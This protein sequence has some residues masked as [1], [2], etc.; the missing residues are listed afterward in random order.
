M[1]DIKFIR[2]NKDIVSAGAKKKHIKFDADNLLAID[3]KRKELLSAVEDLRNKQN[4]AS[5]IISKAASGE[6]RASLIEEMKTLKLALQEK[7]SELAEVMKEWQKLMLVVPNVPDMSVPD[8]ESEEE[9]VEVKKW[10]NLPSFDFPV[11]DHIDLMIGN[12]MVDLER[13]TK[14]HGFRGYFLMNEGA[15]LSFAVWNYARQFFAGEGITEVIAPSIVR[16]EYFYGTGHLPN[17]AEDLFETQDGDYLSGTAEVPMMA[18]H[19][20]EILK[21]E[22]LPKRYLAFSPCF[23]REAGSH[24][25]DTKGLIRVHEFYKF[26]QLI[27]CEGRHEESE[28]LHEEI[29]LKSESFVESLGLPYRRLNVCSGDLSAS[30]V[31]QYEL[32]VWMP[33]QGKYR[34]IGSSSYYHDFQTRRFNIRYDDGGVKRYAHSL[35]N[36]AVATPRVLAAIIENNQREDGKIS[37]PM[38][39]RPFLGGAETIG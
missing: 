36:T 21:K 22:D 23:R 16:K 39:L 17:D 25:K 35:N 12:R 26:E 24:G 27:I 28:R 15:R 8:G 20:G 13:G 34:E 30:K 4:Q 33:F 7:E 9:N 3:D 19:S 5:L 38:V 6:E 2:E 32:E 37:V 14:V 31:K 11:K 1:L 18:F 29:T 10:G